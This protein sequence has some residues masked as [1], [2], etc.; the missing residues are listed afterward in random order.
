MVYVPEALPDLDDT[1]SSIMTLDSDGVS[2]DTFMPNLLGPDFSAPI[3][4][5]LPLIRSPP[6]TSP[7]SSSNPPPI[8]LTSPGFISL[9]EESLNDGEGLKSPKVPNKVSRKRKR[10]TL[11]K[12]VTRTFAHSPG[13]GLSR[14]S[15]KASARRTKENG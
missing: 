12:D 6:P 14:L 1:V 10:D 5:M 9:F 11:E 13:L 2:S 4:P 8:R 7:T 15:A 3:N